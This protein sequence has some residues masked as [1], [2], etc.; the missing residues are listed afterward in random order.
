MYLTTVTLVIFF[1]F[2]IYATIFV[3]EKG[4]A[5]YS[6]ENNNHT[7]KIYDLG[8]HHT[9]DLSE[10]RYYNIISN[11]LDLFIMVFPL[12][13]GFEVFREFIGYFIVIILIRSIFTSVTI[14]PPSKNTFTDLGPIK[15]RVYSASLLLG[16]DYDK[17]FSGHYSVIFLTSLILYRRGLLGSNSRKVLIVLVNVITAFLIIALRYHYSIDILVAIVVCLV[18][19]QNK[20][21]LNL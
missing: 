9:P 2:F 10:S 3:V 8:E 4:D 12:V 15:E 13:F 18:V 5:F 17:I 11:A 1:L 7:A 20:L 16:H 21:K 19:F 6:N 14:L